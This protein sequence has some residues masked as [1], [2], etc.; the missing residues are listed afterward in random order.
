MTGKRPIP[1]KWVDMNKGDATPRGEVT[2]GSCGNQAQDTPSEEALRL[3]VSIVMSPRNK[4]HA[5]DMTKDTKQSQCFIRRYCSV[6]ENVCVI[7]LL[8]TRVVQSAR[9]LLVSGPWLINCQA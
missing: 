8:G 2:L 6:A 1:V 4:V 5:V 9:G 3:L 7:V